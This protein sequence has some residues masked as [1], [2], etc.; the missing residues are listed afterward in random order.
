MKTIKI[1]GLILCA[2]ILLVFAGGLFLKY[3][4]PNI[5]PAEDLKIDITEERKERGEYLAHHVAVC[6]DCHSQ[7]DWSTFSAPLV[8]GSEGAGG[9]VFDQNMG[10]PGFITA[11][12][13]TPYALGSWTD[14]EIYRAITAGV[15]KEGEALFPVMAYHKFAEMDKEDIYSVIAYLRSMP[16]IKNEN[17]PETVLDFPV[18]ILVN[19]EPKVL[20]HKTIPN[21]SDS[22]SYGGYLINAAGCVDCHSTVS[23]GKII[24]GTEYSG[25]MEFKQ[26]NGVLTTP[27]ITMDKETGIGLWTKEIFVSKFKMYADSLYEIPKI[28]SGELNSPMPW[29]M[30]S[31]MTKEDLGAIYDYLNSLKPINN[32]IEVRKHL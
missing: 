23:K 7:R 10:F 27:N 17:I 16:A 22:V 21:K 9:E 26:P 28:K 5:P 1:F 29:V 20:Q 13:I 30:Y 32:K 25:G 8:I 4:L 6:I 14:G 19:L 15:N 24:K 18:N 11:K 2:V 31:G 3:K 12:N